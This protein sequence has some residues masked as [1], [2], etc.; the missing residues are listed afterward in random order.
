M[1][2]GQPLR[3]LE[4]A[5]VWLY[6]FQALRVII[7]VLF[8]IIYDRLI[9][10]PMDAWMVASVLLLA[11]A[12]ALP[13]LAPR[14][15]RAGWLAI[16]AGL[17]MVARIG[18]SINDPNVRYWS[19]LAMIAGAGFYQALLLERAGKASML[20]GIIALAV[21]QTLRAAGQT[22]D[23]S[24]RQSWL[25]VQVALT[26]A[27][28]ILVYWTY[29]R[30]AA[31]RREPVATGALWGLALGGILFIETSLLSLPNAIARWSGAAYY[32]TAPLLL[33]ITVV[34]LHANLRWRLLGWLR[35]SA[36]GRVL[37]GASLP[38]TLLA[39][40]FAQGWLALVAL[41]VA[42]MTTLAA[43]VYLLAGVDRGRNSPGRHLAAGLVFVLALNFLNAFTFT[44]AY[45]LPFLRGLGWTVYLAAGLVTGVAIMGR[46][47]VEAIVRARGLDPNY[48]VLGGFILVGITVVA[49]WPAGALPLASS[50]RLRVATYNMHYG[51]DEAWHLTL[52]AIADTI[53]ADGLDIVAL[54]EVDTGRLTSYAVDNAYYLARRLSMNVLYVPTVEHLTGIALLYRGTASD[55]GSQLLSSRQEQ[56]GIA[57]VQLALDSGPLHAYGIW[58]GLSNEDTLRQI[59]EGIEFI[60]ESSPAVFGG[61]FNSSPDS[62]V[63]AAIREA[64]FADPFATL[65]VQ[66]IPATAPASSPDERIDYVWVRGATP[67]QAW[68]SPSL[69]SDHR[70]VGVEV[71]MGRQGEGEKGRGEEG[72]RSARI[73]R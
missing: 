1:Q 12:L 38:L 60:G 27:G 42:Q 32:L 14:Q 23:L 30:R 37:V 13:A 21:D 20:G 2:R 11:A 33:A 26:A 70:L 41:L 39:G 18:L 66:P 55:T 48:G 71:E 53:E 59:Q 56:T 34:L 52:E 6:T 51:Y 35:G 29:R 24:L 47:R 15:G 61:D 50:G 58:I 40:Y 5:V 49:A 22:Y 7:S 65:G 64:G 73:T 72:F 54:Q 19:A 69:A 44:Y 43:W 28:L 9:I 16:A 62:Q 17:V 8:G 10:G 25:P 57:H 4:A 63:A 68:V 45:T 3:G 31:G 36:R 46:R 67:V